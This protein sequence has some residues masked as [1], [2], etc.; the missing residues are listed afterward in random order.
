MEPVTSLHS[1]RLA[2][3]NQGQVEASTLMEG[4]A[5]DFPVLMMEIWPE[6]AVGSLETGRHWTGVIPS[7][8]TAQIFG[9]GHS[10]N[11]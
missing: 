9:G 7:Q 4:L 5:V 11:Q 2:L 10:G 1:E 8:G 3:L 6:V